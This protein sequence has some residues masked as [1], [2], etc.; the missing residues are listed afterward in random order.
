MSAIRSLVRSLTPPLMLAV[1]KRW[2]GRGQRFVDAGADWKA[3]QSLSLGYS[4]RAIIDRVADA[5]R[6]VV[7]G[8]ASYERDSVQ[9][10]G[11]DY[12]YP[13]LC[14]LMRA[15]ALD[16]GALRVVDLGGSLGSTY[17]QC[18][19]FFQG[20]R[21]VRWLVVEQA[22]LVEIGQREFTTDQISFAP[23]LAQAA[24][25]GPWNVVLASSVLQYLEAPLR[26]LEALAG[27]DAG[28]LLI[29]RT[30][31]H[32]ADSDRLTIQKVPRDI[33]PASY[34]CWILSRQRLLASLESRW[35]LV[36]E[37]ACDEGR[38]RTEAGLP[39]E[40]RGFYLERRH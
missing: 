33:Y 35:R 31:V 2:S 28:H 17:W 22:A 8:R 30:P 39:F 24:A 27:I 11:Q 19:P 23:S 13:L 4:D 10:S 32:D 15:A 25:R 5:T 34:P 38:A 14:A 18:R 26:S 9:F 20:L 37:F 16:Q 7:E 36:H 1:A 6:A 21:E 3:A 12:R 29:D 40:F